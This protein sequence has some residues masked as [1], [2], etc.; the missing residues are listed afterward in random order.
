MA[1][2][3]AM[4]LFADTVRLGSFSQAARNAGL[5]PGSVSRRISE[6]EQGL[7]VQLFSR[8]TRQ[9]ALTEAGRVYFQHIE[10]V[11][12]S[13][14]E[15]ES[16]AAALQET[17]RGT[18]RI[19]SR[20]LFGLL[21][22]S[23]LIPAFRERY[24]D[25]KVELRLSE[26]PIQLR[27]E[28]C[29]IDFRIAPPRDAG[30]MQRKLFSSQRVLLASP[31]YLGR[32][33]A[34]ETPSDLAHHACLSYLI[35]H[36]EPVWRF[37]RD[38]KLEEMPVPSSFSVNNGMILRDLALSG[39]GIALLDDYTVTE[40][41]ERGALVRVLERYRVTNTT[42]D[43]GMYATYLEVAHVAEK[44]RV[45]LDFLVAELKP[46]IARRNAVLSA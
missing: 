5:T 40:E 46:M 20:T 38:G 4:R 30:L 9:I 33:A 21:V 25:I 2:L 7:G 1:R 24:P 36:D 16:A 31:S 32:H 3:Q 35:G 22:L 45:F 44:I 28:D 19:H 8:T 34:I 6:L 23:R 17:P 39:H 11:L 42:F 43:E 13:I 15:A 29:D 37:L 41:L 14:L 18:L 10:K 26:R 27:E 12:D